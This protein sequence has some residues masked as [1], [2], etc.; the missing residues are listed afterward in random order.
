MLEIFDSRPYGG[1]PACVEHLRSLDIRIGQRLGA[2]I[3][4]LGR[5]RIFV[6]L[7]LLEG[8]APGTPLEELLLAPRWADARTLEDVRGIVGDRPDVACAQEDGLVKVVSRD[9]LDEAETAEET[10]DDEG[11]SSLL[12]AL[13]GTAPRIAAGPAAAALWDR[14]R[15]EQAALAF[16]DSEDLTELVEQLRYL[17]RAALLSGLDP[18]PLLV[19][20]LRRRKATLSLEVASLVR[21]HLHRDLGRA[22]EDLLGGD[23]GRLRDG[24]HFVFERQESV[25]PRSLVQLVLPA[26]TA[27][28][29]QARA[30]RI[31]LGLLPSAVPLVEMSAGREDVVEEF[32]DGILAEL[33][34][35]E[36]PERLRLSQFLLAAQ[37]AYP[38]LDDLL[39]RRLVARAEPHE[40]A[41]FGNVLSRMRLGDDL[42]HRT[43]AHLAEALVGHPNDV[44]LQE[45]LRGT[46]LNLGVPPL[47]LLMEPERRARMTPNL[48]TWLLELWNAY[49]AA[50][51][52][53]PPLDGMAGLLLGEVAARNR[54]AL[55][56]TLRSGLIAHPAV[57][58]HLA[59]NPWVQGTVLHVLLEEI[60]NLEDP[61]DRTLV[62]F[63]A[64]LG[65]EGL[66]AAFDR[67]REETALDA[68]SAPYRFRCFALLAAEARLDPS[69]HE[70]L[71]AMIEESLGFPFAHQARLPV[72]VEAWGALGRVA[73][74]PREMLDDLLDRILPATLGAA[75]AATGTVSRETFSTISTEGGESGP[76]S[77]PPP[78]VV[79]G[80][81]S[82]FRFADL[83]VQA[84]LAIHGNPASAGPVRERIEERF[85]QVLAE[86][87][88]PRDLLVAV[89]DGLETLLARAELPVR[90][91]RMAVILAR[92]VLRKSRESSLDHVLKDM[93]RED[94]EGHG[95]RL[96][97][98]WGKEDRDRALVILG[99]VAAHAATPEPLHRMMASRL[100]GFLDDWLDA[101]ESG[102]NLYLHRDTP[103]WAVLLDLVR[104]RRSEHTVEAVVRVG[105]RA[106]EAHRKAPRNMALDR[107]EDVQRLVAELIWLGPPQ[108]VEVRGSLRLDI[109]RTAFQTL[110]NLA[111]RESPTALR[112]LAELATRDDLPPRFR[113]PL[114]GFLAF[115]RRP[116]GG[117]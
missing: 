32:L 10:A 49:L 43:A 70:A 113:A 72:V 48:R 25:E 46:F 30:L 27:V 77:P 4:A 106:I 93:L 41:F 58:D 76:H 29:G 67:A 44:G 55:V 22:L 8:A 15:L 88:P 62:A 102:A 59:A 107:R 17:F 1:G 87:Q 9:E 50:G 80:P 117:D 16:L 20:A 40:Q 42:R 52:D 11:S 66:Q 33:Q 64:Q 98:A 65:L 73:V 13:L 78:G 90:L 99:R 39:F 57:A 115:Q 14:T 83:R 6:S 79:A 86:E 37:G 89:L 7:A 5:R 53:H 103:L 111:T 38:R 101:Q 31:V 2:R 18:V 12:P 51:Q 68:R 114:D 60:L 56:S 36:A 100:A 104:A 34:E 71:Q 110:L 45:R 97:E 54:G 75:P 116:A 85:E 28:L 109:P 108:P 69:E 112:V 81:P 63:L 91:E 21:Q 84:A 92:V 95:V 94:A 3:H 23:E 74:L 26:V 24:I 105:L 82:P 96:L 35:L 19:S 61:D 47:A